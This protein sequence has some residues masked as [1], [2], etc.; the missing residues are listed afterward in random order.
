MEN[1]QAWT[2]HQYGVIKLLVCAIE[3]AHGLIPTYEMITMEQ[4]R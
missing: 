4:V 3:A 2:E 1:E